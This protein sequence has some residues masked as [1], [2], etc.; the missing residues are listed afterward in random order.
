MDKLNGIKAVFWDWDGT[1]VDSFAFLHKT[2]NHVRQKFG[3]PTFSVEEFGDYFGK[4][5]ELL[6][7]DIYGAENIEEAKGHFEAFVLANHHEIQP[8]AG[9]YD[10]LKTFQGLGLPMAIVT[11]KK[12]PLVSKE[13]SN[14]GWDDFF[15]CT[16][17]AGEAEEDK[18][19][20]APLHLALEKSGL[21][22][23]AEEVL[24][25]GDTE[26]DV[27]CA[28]GAGAKIAFIEEDL[29]KHKIADEYDALLMFKNCHEFNDFL[30]QRS[31]KTL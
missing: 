31:E 16:I 22:I 24:F 13:I 6:Y 21:G 3:M 8:M 11:N 20:S 14:H 28:H 12:G 27:L 25:V 1:L 17:G 7:R 18:P 29:G 2:H 10:L 26:N 23:A 4:P 9:A 15:A 5:R 19:S 30:L